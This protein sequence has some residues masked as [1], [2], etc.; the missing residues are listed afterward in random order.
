MYEEP[1]PCVF[2][3][4][5]LS[6]S[7][8][9]KEVFVT[10]INGEV[11]GAVAANDVGWPAG[12]GGTL[13]TT[14]A[15]PNGATVAV[16]AAE[17]AGGVVVAAVG[18]AVAVV[19]AAAVAAAAG[20]ESAV[21]GG[22]APDAVAAR[23]IRALDEVGWPVPVENRGNRRQSHQTSGFRHPL[24]MPKRPPISKRLQL[25]PLG[26]DEPRRLLRP[27]TPRWKSRLPCRRRRCLLVAA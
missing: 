7:P 24:P 16:A 1:R 19:V 3:L 17:S 4:L 6:L 26:G 14:D 8:Q 18:G 20:T 23:R 2:L 25:R 5:I 15:G 21:G 9:Q 27:S 12:V 22:G 10:R 11:V 13:E